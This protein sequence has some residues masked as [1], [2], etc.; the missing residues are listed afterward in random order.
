MLYSF[1]EQYF[2]EN[3]AN[4]LTNHKKTIIHEIQSGQMEGVVNI[5]KKF[6]ASPNIMYTKLIYCI[7]L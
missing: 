5:R 7:V 1:T 4:I 6:L 3:F 2:L